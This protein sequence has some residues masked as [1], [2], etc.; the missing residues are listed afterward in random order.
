V[1]HVKDLVLVELLLEKEKKKNEL[2][3]GKSKGLGKGSKVLIDE[4]RRPV[5]QTVTR[6]RQSQLVRVRPAA[7][8]H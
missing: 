6:G 2:G 5:G 8:R 4:Q 7:K 1:G 3:K